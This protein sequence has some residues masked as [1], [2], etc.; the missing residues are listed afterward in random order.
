MQVLFLPHSHESMGD[1]KTHQS[2]IVVP[3]RPS[4]NAKSNPLPISKYY[5]TRVK[6][7]YSDLSPPFP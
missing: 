7:T 4:T 3:D 2:Y 1:A 5:P 6:E